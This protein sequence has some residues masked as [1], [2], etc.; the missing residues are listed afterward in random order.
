MIEITRLNE[1]NGGNRF[2]SCL[3]CGAFSK[4]DKS[5][6]RITFRT[7]QQGTS[8][9]LCSKCTHSLI[10]HMSRMNNNWIKPKNYQGC[11]NCKHQPEPLQTCDWLKTQNSIV[12]ICPGWELKSSESKE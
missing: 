11:Q 5:L 6:I 4:D 7:E 9:C 2:G 12:I 10:R 8:I 3:S 1:C